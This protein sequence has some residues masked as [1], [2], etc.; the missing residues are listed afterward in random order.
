LDQIEK[1]LKNLL[2]DQVVEKELKIFIIELINN[3][4]NLWIIFDTGNLAI[5]GAQVTFFNI[6]PTGKKMLNLDHTGGKNMQDWVEKGIDVMTKFAKENGC[7]GIEG[8]GRHGQ[9]HWVKNKK[10][11]KRP[12]S[13][14]EYNFEEKQ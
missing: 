9:W 13:M 10:G 8:V 5:T 6:Y 7:E 12:A 14:Y 1:F 3:K 4:T 2:I 11:W